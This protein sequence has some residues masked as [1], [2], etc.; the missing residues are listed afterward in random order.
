[1]K[2]G[3]QPISTTQGYDFIAHLLTARDLPQA[4]VIPV[5]WGQF[6][7]S[8]PGATNWGALKHLFPPHG[9]S[10]LT[11]SPQNPGP[12]GSKRQRRVN[13]LT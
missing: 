5:D 1:M 6:A 4:A 11:L 13:V 8:I 7:Q 2:D 10:A 3:R 12:N 9:S